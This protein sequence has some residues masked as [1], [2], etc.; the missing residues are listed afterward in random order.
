MVLKRKIYD[1]LLEWKENSQGK[2]AIMVEGARRIGK[3]TIVEEFA[4]KENYCKYFF[5]KYNT[6][7]DSDPQFQEVR[8]LL[9]VAFSRAKKNLYVIYKNNTPEN[10]L[11]N[12]KDIF[13]E[14]HN[15]NSY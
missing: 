14:I 2:K 9:Y 15:L 1:K 5:E 10:L 13:Q 3:S 11:A 12:I 6:S 8:N 4:K 7:I